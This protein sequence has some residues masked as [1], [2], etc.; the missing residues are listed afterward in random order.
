M[1]RISTFVVGLFSISETVLLGSHIPFRR[2]QGA[3]QLGRRPKPIPAR[4][5]PGI[6]CSTMPLSDEPIRPMTL[7][8]MRSLGVRR[9]FNERVG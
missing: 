2:R 6:E 7:G 3:D 8:N 5:G 4:R 1:T 9:L